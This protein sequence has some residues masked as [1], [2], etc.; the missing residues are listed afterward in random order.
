MTHGFRP[1]LVLHARNTHGRFFGLL[2]PMKINALRC[3]EGDMSSALFIRSR[4]IFLVLSLIA[5][6]PLLAQEAEK[7]A[8]A[9][10]T[11]EE[12]GEWLQRAEVMRDEADRRYVAEEA[13]CYRKVLVSGCLEDARERRMQTIVGAQKLE[14][15]ARE[16]RR[17]S[18]R[19]EVGEEKERQAAKRSTREAEQRERAERHRA[20]EAEKAAERE[21]RRL[22]KE[23][24]AEEKRRKLAERRAERKLKADE[25]T[26][27]HARQIEKKAGQR[28]KAKE[29]AASDKAP[30]ADGG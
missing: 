13:A 29:K 22:K 20:G 8:S 17:A 23:R 9:P 2:N 19:A 28:E 15:P 16:F 21:Q 11:L 1:W 6:L 4:T 18:R 24:K 7:P 12:A 27:R 5:G 14:I 26:R 30:A 25:R 3:L 10:Q